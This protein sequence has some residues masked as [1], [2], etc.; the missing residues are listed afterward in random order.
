VIGFCREAPNPTTVWLMLHGNAGQACD[1]EYVIERMSPN[2]SLY[3]LEYPGYG[4]RPG[5]PSQGAI[6]SAA[7]QAFSLLVEA[8]PRLAVCIVGESLGSGPACHLASLERKPDKL[9]LIVPYDSICEVAE[10]KFFFL[11]VRL[12]LSDRW[13]NIAALKSYK[14]PVE[15][16]AA[17]DD[18]IIPVQH[19]ERLAK[20]CPTSILNIVPCGHNDWSSSLAIKISN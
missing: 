2:D 18:D 7:R 1:R 14:G 10:R 17:R 5:R 11:P 19:A 3:V 12:L 13:D 8:H 9:V 4:Q 16:F 15:I 20:S 6:N